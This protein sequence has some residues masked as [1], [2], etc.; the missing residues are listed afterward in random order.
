MQK[1]LYR[2]IP[3]TCRPS[4]PL[5]NNYYT[6]F[7]N[8]GEHTWNK[9]TAY[10]VTLL[11]LGVIRCTNDSICQCF[12]DVC[13]QNLICVDTN[14]AYLCLCVHVIVYTPMCVCMCAHTC[15][16]TVCIYIFIYMCVF[17]WVWVSEWVSGGRGSE[18]R[19]ECWEILITQKQCREI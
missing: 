12:I 4:W 5:D 10:D 2:S 3:Y 19:G 1:C 14:C 15:D 13:T 9:T 17:V 16:C 7:T 6:A 8:F 18:Y 11:M